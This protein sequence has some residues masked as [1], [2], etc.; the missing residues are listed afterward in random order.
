MIVAK[1]ISFMVITS[2]VLA[3]TFEVF[4]MIKRAS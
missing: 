3:L 4:K 2:V 1:V